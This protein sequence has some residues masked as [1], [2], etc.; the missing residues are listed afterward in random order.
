MDTARLLELARK[1][2]NAKS[3]FTSEDIRY[4]RQ[5]DERDKALA[6]YESAQQELTDFL[7]GA[8]SE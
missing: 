1:V 4:N 2:E 8:A 3:L 5:K 7:N 6:I